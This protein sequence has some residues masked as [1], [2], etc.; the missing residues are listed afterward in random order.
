[1]KSKDHVTERNLLG[2]SALASD[3]LN[4]DP[5]IPTFSMWQWAHY[6]KISPSFCLFLCKMSVT[7][8]FHWGVLK[9]K[10]FWYLQTLPRNNRDSAWNNFHYFYILPK[11]IPHFSQ[12]LNQLNQTC[13][14]SSEWQYTCIQP[15]M[16][17][18]LGFY[19]V[20]SSIRVSTVVAEQTWDYRWL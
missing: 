9:S 18:W 1:M 7:Y 13:S 19:Q 10:R 16:A 8:L 4:S 12:S 15:T 3:C 6:G 17:I 2:N 14:E 5:H 11:C 20:A